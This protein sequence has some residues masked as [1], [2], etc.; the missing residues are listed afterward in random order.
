MLP[1][2]VSGTS[3]TTSHI[4]NTTYP[5]PA[6]TD[7]F[8]HYLT[9]GTYVWRVQ[10]VQRRGSYL[11]FRATDTFTIV[12]PPVVTGQ[13]LALDG[14]ALDDETTCDALLGPDQSNELIC[15]GVPATPVLDWDP[16]P[17]AAYYMIY[18]ANDRELTNRVFGNSAA[19]PV[20]DEHSLDTHVS[21]G[22]GSPRRQPGR[23]VLLLVCPA[24]Q[25]HRQVRLPTRSRQHAAATNGF[26]KLSPGVQ[27]A[28]TSDG[29]IRSRR[30]HLRMG[31][32]LR[33][34]P[35]GPAVPGRRR[36]PAPD[37]AEVPHR[38]L[39]VADVRHDR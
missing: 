23:P 20:H 24:L 19:D 1:D 21:D 34:Q 38:D 31:R 12:D 26:R 22:Q 29:R 27:L 13:S 14:Q 32:L 8:D 17:E 33:H 7:T 16:V 30:H 9:P 11:G 15:E 18:L 37:R 2:P 25:G 28:D 10:G 4:N 35:S 36:A 39:P 5:Y 3:T 6:A